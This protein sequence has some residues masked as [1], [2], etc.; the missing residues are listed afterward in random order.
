MSV[1]SISGGKA[2]LVDTVKTQTSARTIALDPRSGRLYMPA[3]KP[4]P[5]GKGR[6]PGTFELLVA[7]K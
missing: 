4:G 1:I 7:G 5:D 3:A 6:A 2:V